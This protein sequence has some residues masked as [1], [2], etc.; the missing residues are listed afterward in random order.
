MKATTRDILTGIVAGI[1]ALVFVVPVNAASIRFGNAIIPGTMIRKDVL[2]MREHRYVNLVPQN[3]DFSC[4]AAALATILRY[5]Y[6]KDVN[7]YTVLKGMLTITDIEVVQQR[8]F[9]LLDIKNYVE[10]IGM[11][12][13]G[14]KVEEATLDEVAIPTIVLL[15]LNGYKHFVVLKKASGDRV[16]VADPALGNRIMS[17]KDFLNSWNNII[18]AIIGSDFNR[19]TV[20]L[21][22]AQPLT[23][24][25][26]HDVFAP[27]PQQQLLDFGFRH[28]DFL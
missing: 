1:L 20:L 19:N 7:E 17:R 8:G 28:A 3:T 21:H 13:R 14:Y 11:R 27:V 16:Y 24:R 25:R 23:A 10:S 15:D 22:P 2:S 18:F 4:G 5:A 12:G 26:L 9:S 6:G